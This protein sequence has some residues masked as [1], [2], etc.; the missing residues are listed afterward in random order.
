MNKDERR[1]RQKLSGIAQDHIFKYWGDLDTENR[2]HL[3]K[4]IDH[5]DLQVFRSQQDVL[6]RRG[7]PPFG[8]IES[9]GD[10]APSQNIVDIDLGRRLM[11]Q[12]KVGCLVV[13]GGQG[14]RLR[15][16]GPKGAYPLSPIKNKS[17]FQMLAEKTI[18]AGKQAGKMLRLAIMTS[19]QNH[20]ET[21][22]FFRDHDNFGLSFLQLNFFSQ[23]E[24]PLLNIEGDLFLE[25]KHILSMGPDGNG[26]SLKNFVES[27]IWEDWKRTGIE[28][29]NFV[30]IDNPLADPFDVNLVGLHASKSNDVTIK[31]IERE[32]PQENVGILVKRSG[33]IEVIEYSE[34][35]PVEKTAVMSDGI[36]KHRCANIS[37]FCFSMD[38]I[39]EA[40]ARTVKMPF[41]LAFKFAKTVN[42]GGSVDEPNAWKFERFIFDVLSWTFKVSAMVCPRERCFAP[43]K[44]FEGSDSPK[45]VQEALIKIDRCVLEELTG[46]PPPAHTF[47][48][49]QDFH[50]P[51]SDLKEKLKGCVIPLLDY[52]SIEDLCE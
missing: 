25:D 48:L 49:S 16:N 22:R 1:A 14:T 21:I 6:K 45:M 28:Y 15:A 35:P 19:P 11:S 23:G 10:L 30:L 37:L 38:F 2:E 42:E 4:Q 31:C 9:F 39:Q 32:D 26:A 5:L 51:T 44:N 12:G 29:V 17:L 20:E 13:A 46:L 34:M 27:G 7:S 40:A 52:Y 18:A 50:Y 33:H 47:E 24:L 8:V 36:L 3:L 41:H 43:L